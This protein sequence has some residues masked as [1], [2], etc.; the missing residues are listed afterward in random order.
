VS[1]KATA[2][3]REQSTGDPTS[4]LVLLLMA[5][6]TAPPDLDATPPRADW[7]SW[8]SIDRLARLSECSVST[9]RR[10]VRRLEA[11]GLVTTVARPG[12]T[13]FYVL[14]VGPDRLPD[15]VDNQ[16]PTPVN[17]TGVGSDPGQSDRGPRS[18]LWQGTP[19]TAM[20]AELEGTEGEPKRSAD[21]ASV[22]NAARARELRSRL[23]GAQTTELEAG[24]A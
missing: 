1:W 19:V 23:N 5:D 13:S 11:L 4:K 12:R 14:P 10:H 22:D 15:P 8:V 17:L 6:H 3:A 9:A 16:S 20:T 21:S 7:R 24:Q 18:Q 2:W